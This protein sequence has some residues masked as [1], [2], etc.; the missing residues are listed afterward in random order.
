MKRE[1][2]HRPF[3]RSFWS[4]IRARRAGGDPG[5]LWTVEVLR[6][7]SRQTIECD[8]TPRVMGRIA[9]ELGRLRLLTPSPRVSRLAWASSLLLACSALAFLG[10]TLFVL[11]LGGDEGV[12]EIVG[13]GISGWHVLMVF[14]RVAADLGARVLAF[15]LPILRTGWALL[16]VAAPLLRGAGLLAAACGVLSILFSTYVFA[17]ARKTAPRVDLLGGIR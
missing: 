7:L 12:R 17:S 5:G 14:G 8:V 9:A 13:V 15:V 1:P 2:G 6:P 3:R 10:S 4:V 16:E 11:V